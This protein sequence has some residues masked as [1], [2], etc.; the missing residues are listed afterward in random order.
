M[1]IQEHLGDEEVGNVPDSEL[2]TRETFISY[3][4]KGTVSASFFYPDLLDG[5]EAVEV[6]TNQLNALIKPAIDCYLADD[7]YFSLEAGISNVL[8]IY[9]DNFIRYLRFNPNRI[10]AH[11]QEFNLYALFKQNEQI[12][13]SMFEKTNIYDPKDDITQP[14]IA[15][16]PT[17]VFNSAG[18]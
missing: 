7:G 8:G 9:N 11:L 15:W 4:W 16:V 13:I 14:L 17:E 12:H 5:V 10:T 18:E 3:S 1:A 2:D 6:D